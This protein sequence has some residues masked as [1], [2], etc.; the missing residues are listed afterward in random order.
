MLDWYAWHVGQP[1]VEVVTHHLYVERPRNH[2]RA[3]AAIAPAAP[4]AQ[5]PQPARAMAAIQWDP[6][7]QQPAPPPQ[8]P[9]PAV[10]D[11]TQQQADI[12]ELLR[13]MV[14]QNA[15]IIELLQVVANNAA[16]RG[17]VR[18]RGP[19]AAPAAPRATTPPSGAGSPTVPP[20][21]GLGQD[22]G[23]QTHSNP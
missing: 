20:P 21:P 11:G 23:I 17:P 7:P 19:Q 13:R 14:E 1:I 18:A 16:M 4:A 8:P 3:A 15:A 9:P 22:D 6:Q 12:I 2:H 10:A 5:Q